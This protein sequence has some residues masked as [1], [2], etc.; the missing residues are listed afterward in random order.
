MLFFSTDA[1][2]IFVK[3]GKIGALTTSQFLQLQESVPCRFINPLCV[4]NP[5]P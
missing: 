3:K 4:E 2:H 1:C 5:V